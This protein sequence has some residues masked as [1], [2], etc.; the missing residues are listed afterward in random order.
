MSSSERN[1]YI[2]GAIG[3]VVV[4][5]FVAY[6]SGP[7]IWTVLLCAVLFAALCSWLWGY[8]IAPFLQ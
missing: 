8:C 6:V 3:G 4:G 7:T 1:P 5:V 2:W